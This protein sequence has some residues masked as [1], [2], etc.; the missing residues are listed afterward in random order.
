MSLG[1]KIEELRKSKGLTLKE[2]S[3][4]SKVALTT[5]SRIENDKMRGTIDSHLHI[6]KALGVSLTELY[7]EL[8]EEKKK[9]SVVV[10]P[11]GK[12]TD[13]YT[14]NKFSAYE[15]LTKDVLKK[16][17]MPILLK[18]DPRGTTNKEEH[19]FATEKFVYCLEGDVEATVG[20]SKY[21]L[22][23]G[24]TLYFDGSMQHQF[25]NLGKKQALCIC[26]IDPPAL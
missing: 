25:K 23:K 7:N 4:S 20:S 26:V 15:I 3:D 14:H 1:K 22:S 21:S 8:E 18:I 17:M 9:S 6:A 12:R 13:I 16:K 19:Q 5:L 10:Q 11:K 24:D 2:L